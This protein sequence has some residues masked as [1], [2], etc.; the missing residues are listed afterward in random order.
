MLYD[1][2]GGALLPHT[3]GERVRKTLGVLPR[4]L[5]ASGSDPFRDIYFLKAHVDA[6]RFSHTSRFVDFIF[7]LGVYTALAPPVCEML[8]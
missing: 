4:A 1:S 2:T 7:A 6:R 3:Y 8:E 5:S